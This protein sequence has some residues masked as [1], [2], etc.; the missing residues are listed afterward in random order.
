MLDGISVVPRAW[1][2]YV[3][4]DEATI[5]TQAQRETDGRHVW[6]RVSLPVPRRG[7][8]RH[9]VLRRVWSPAPRVIRARKT[10]TH[11]PIHAALDKECAPP[12]TFA[13]PSHTDT[14]GARTVV[15]SALNI[16]AFLL[17][18]DLR[19]WRG[20]RGCVGGDALCGTHGVCYP[21]LR[22]GRSTHVSMPMPKYTTKAKKLKAKAV[23]WVQRGRRGR[24]VAFERV[25]G[26]ESEG[27]SNQPPPKHTHTTHTTHHT[28]NILNP[29]HSPSHTTHTTQHRFELP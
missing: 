11:T 29:H 8:G 22:R 17:D 15:A 28:H 24:K 25:G 27:F 2:R 1:M 14:H 6:E 16:C 4:A 9:R 19:W 5:C 18:A 7:Q 21:P 12:R 10:T 20:R 26:G 23:F 3:S 13:V